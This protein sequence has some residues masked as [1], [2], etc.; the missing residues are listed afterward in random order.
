MDLLCHPL[1]GMRENSFIGLSVCHK[2]LTWLIS[3]EVLMIEHGYLACMILVTTLSTGTMLWPWPWPLTYFRSNFYAPGLRVPPGASSDR[4]VRPSVCQS[5]RNS[6]PLTIKV[7]CLKF[8]WWY[9]YQ[10]W[11]VSLSKGCSHFTDITRPWG[12]GGVKM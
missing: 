1:A 11:T 8:G 4:I 7:Q 9:N 6:V 2:N 5:V 10:T 12:W 3:S